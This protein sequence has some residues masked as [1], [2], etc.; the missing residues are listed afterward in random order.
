MK[1]EID[2]DMCVGHGVCENIRSD[3]FEVRDD[4]IA[5]LLTEELSEADRRDI[6]DAVNQ[7]PAYALR[8]EE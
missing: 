4:G 2:I 3:L 8:L 6:E 1:I 7:C 5:H